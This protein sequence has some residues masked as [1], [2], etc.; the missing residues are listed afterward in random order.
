MSGRRNT[1]IPAP[2]FF[3]GKKRTAFLA[4]LSIGL[5]A[6]AVLKS[7]GLPEENMAEPSPSPPRFPQQ[8]APLETTP[9]LPPV[10]IRPPALQSGD[11]IAL[12]TPAS[13]AERSDVEEAAENLTRRGF[14]VKISPAVREREGYLAG[15]DALRVEALHRAFSDPEVRMIL[16]VRGGFGSPRLLD[17]IDY[18]L[19]R[20]HP[21]IFVGYSDITSLLIAIHQR[22]GLVTFHGPMAGTDFSGRGGLSPFA[23]QHLFSLVGLKPFQLEAEPFADW[24]GSSQEW[25]E[26]RRTLS[27]GVAEG[28]LIGG[29]LSTIAALMGTPFEIDTR[30]AIL[31]LE[32]VNEEPFRIDRMLC[33]LR[34][35]RK[36]AVARGILLGSFTNCVPRSPRE[37]FTVWEVLQAYFAEC[38]IPVLAGFPAGHLPE[39]ASLPFGSRIRLDATARTLSIL[40]PAVK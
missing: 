8:S 18:D 30:G 13:P 32:D 2:L 23:A 16:C 35:A 37:S 24:G 31:F 20:R 27:E 1:H 5:A 29:N 9:P 26:S 34:L 15:T 4:F 7:R 39:Q 33:Q 17:K 6:L 38:G 12:I 3:F 22:T 14:R 10:V 36:F 21:K 40:E 28:T 19:V 11:T 25:V